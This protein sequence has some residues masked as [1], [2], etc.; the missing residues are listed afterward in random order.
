[1]VASC[2]PPAGDL[3]HDPGMCPDWNQIS[4]V[5]VRRLV[6]NPLSHTSQGIFLFSKDAQYTEENLAN[7]VIHEIGKMAGKL[8]LSTLSLLH[9]ILNGI[10][11]TD[12]EN[13]VTNY[14]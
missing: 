12:H 1:M 14:Q 7:L 13:Q 6:F 11:R 8:T 10:F 4:D 5:L 3:A 9:I 2:T